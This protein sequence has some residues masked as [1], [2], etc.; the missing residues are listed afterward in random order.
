M[1]LLP[2][3]TEE[4]VP[5]DDP[6]RQRHDAFIRKCGQDPSK[7]VLVRRTLNI[8]SSAYVFTDDEWATLRDVFSRVLHSGK[9]KELAP[10]ET[11]E[12]F[13]EDLQRLCSD[14]MYW[15]LKHPERERPERDTLRTRRERIL[16]DCKAA[17]GHLRQIVECE[18]DLNRFD[19][20]VPSYTDFD[21]HFFTVQADG[22]VVPDGTAGFKVKSWSEA[23]DAMETLTQFIETLESYHSAEERLGHRPPAERDPFLSR[24]ADLYRKHIT[25]QPST[26]DEGCF[27]G[28]VQ[29]VR[30]ILGEKGK[31]YPK[32][33]VTAALGKS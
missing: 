15:F 32:K 29:V 3:F 14:R 28:V 13:I 12:A 10:G 21:D 16:T 6:Y 11:V 5:P 24:I 17:L 25:K 27:V 22:K 2:P 4:V 23:R 7:V 19:D 1:K 20:T 26:Y 33:A 8:G 9:V 31:K 18:V 30:E